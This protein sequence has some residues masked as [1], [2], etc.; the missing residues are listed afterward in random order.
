MRHFTFV[1]NILNHTLLNVCLYLASWLFP[2]PISIVKVIINTLFEHSIVTS[3]VVRFSLHVYYPS[4][5]R[6]AFFR[7]PLSFS[8]SRLFIFSHFTSAYPA[9]PAQTNEHSF[10][11]RNLHSLISA[12]IRRHCCLSKA[13][14]SASPMDH[15]DRKVWDFFSGRHR[16]SVHHRQETS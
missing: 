15:G 9:Y 16:Y 4:I 5:E 6:I 14:I 8:S 10:H 3:H 13:A 2:A 7:H 1:Q 11:P 12:Y